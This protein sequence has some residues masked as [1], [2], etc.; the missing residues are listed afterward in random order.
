LAHFR[1]NTNGRPPG[2][3]DAK[4]TKKSLTNN[5]KCDRMF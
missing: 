4:K 3:S 1:E 2:G 5:K